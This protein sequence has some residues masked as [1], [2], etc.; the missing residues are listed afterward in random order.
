MTASDSEKPQSDYTNRRT[1]P[2]YSLIATVD[3]IESSSDMR[4][5]GRLSEVSRKGA[6]IDVL[7]ALPKGTLVKIRVS[8]DCGTFATAAKIIYVQEGMGMGVAFMDTPEDQLSVLDAWLAE[9]GS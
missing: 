2:R 5:S 9:L 8:R 3:V 4:L 7:N 6:Y 1:V